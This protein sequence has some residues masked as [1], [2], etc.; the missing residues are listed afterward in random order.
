VLLALM[1]LMVV[2]I[3]DRAHGF[4]PRGG[5]NLNQQLRYATWP[6]REFDTN[7][8]GVIEQG[9]GLEFRI[10]G[11]PRGFTLDEIEQVKAGFKVWHDVPTSYVALRFAGVIEDPIIPGIGLPDYLPT[12]FMQVNRIAENDGYSQMDDLEFQIPEL[13]GGLIGIALAL[14]TIDMTPV[15]VGGNVVMVPAGSILDCDII[16]DAAY[17]RTGLLTDSTFGVLDLQAAVTKVVGSL[18]GLGDT[19][20]NNLDPFND[21]AGLPVEPAVMQLTGSDGLARMVG[22]TPTMFPAYFLTQMPNGDYIPGWSDL[23]PDD[24]SGISWLYPREDGLE[25]FFNVEHE[26]RTQVRNATGIPPAPISGAHIVAWADV[27]DS[28]SGRRVPMFSTMSGLYEMYTDTQLSGRFNM[29]GL[30]KQLEVPGKE[31]TLFEPSYVMTMSPLNGLGYDRQAPPG[32]TSSMF[33]SIQSAF[34]V[35]FSTIVRPATEFSTNY[36]SEVFNEDGNIYGVDNY[37]AGTPL[38]WSFEKNALISM[39][40]NKTLPR[41]LPRNMP[42]FGDPDTVCPM[43]I[44]E[45]IDGIALPAG[46]GSLNNK[47]RNFRDNTLLNSAVG[48][49]VVEMYY[50]VAPYVGYQMFR[51]DALMRMVRGGVVTAMWMWERLMSIL[52]LGILSGIMAMVII[53]RHRLSP[54]GIAVV[55]MALLLCVAA[56]SHATQLPMSTEE[57]VAQ[58]THIISGKVLSAEG[59]LGVNN[60]I[61]TNV[62]FEISDVAKGDLNRGSTITFSVIGGQYGTLALAAT[63]IPGFVAGEHAVL[64]LVDVPNYG[65]VPQGGLHSKVPIYVD[66]DTEEE[67]VISSEGE[68][69]AT[70]GE[71]TE[72]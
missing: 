58:S 18:L 52:I 34:P 22:A 9:E 35:S 29:Q 48:T 43:N 31:G 46:I 51:H 42:M 26:A 36:P 14:Y 47:L 12:V 6:F 30:W 70:E 64:H 65:L 61:Y 24:I 63:G 72:G 62:A 23:A 49:A 11:G 13:G 2:G 59:A 32:M 44:I 67:E 40:S 57:M 17:Y 50:R 7:D 56:A 45:N 33:D 15:P 8:N 53:K 3:A 27:T 10:E 71:V 19:P 28:P 39:N 68:G 60:R 20:L 1:V 66:P 4:F 54:A 21:L 16:L 55:V 41:I 38:A 5:Y 25:N 69:E 37:A